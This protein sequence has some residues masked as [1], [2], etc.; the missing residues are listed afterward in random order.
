[1]E[2]FKLNFA[3]FISAENYYH[4]IHKF[5]SK[6]INYKYTFFE[7][8]ELPTN[9]I[10]I[11]VYKDNVETFFNPELSETIIIDF[12]KDFLKNNIPGM[13]NYYLDLLIQKAHTANQNTPNNLE[14]FFMPV[15]EELNRYSG[16]YSKADF[17]PDDI[18]QLIK[19]EVNKLI[20]SLHSYLSNPYPDVKK[21]LQFKLNRIDVEVFF[22]LLRE[23][24]I[25]AHI[26]DADLGRIIDNLCEFQKKEGTN[27]FVSINGS[28]GKITGI[29]NKDRIVD[30]SLRKL[31][32]IFCTNFFD[33]NLGSK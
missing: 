10:K 5:L 11:E 16:C 13:A 2:P 27:E 18:R 20:E 4:L 26:E 32:K 6:D 24:K 29:K 21:K 14:Y 22:F 3:D 28:A 8:L 12:E 30:K 7:D 23:K 17:L 25:I 31:S 9:D 19:F 33:Y 15:L 1:M